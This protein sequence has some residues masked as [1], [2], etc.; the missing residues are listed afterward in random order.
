MKTLLEIHRLTCRALTEYRS[1][2]F[3]LGSVVRVANPQFKGFG[4]VATYDCRPDQ[5]GVRLENHN[6]WHYA[7]ET[8]EPEPN[9]KMWPPWIQRDMRQRRGKHAWKKAA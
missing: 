2:D 4:I 6:I 1:R 3:P 7:L 5:L 8:I 9:R